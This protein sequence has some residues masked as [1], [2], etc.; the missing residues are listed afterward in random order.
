MED[1][2]DAFDDE[3]VITPKLS[4]PQL[5]S[6]FLREHHKKIA[7]FSSLIAIILL[8][9]VLIILGIWI[10]SGSGDEETNTSWSYGVVIDMGSSGSRIHVFQWSIN[11]PVQPAPHGGETSIIQYNQKHEHHT[12]PNISIRT[13][14]LV[15]R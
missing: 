6:I 15:H 1:E 7:L 10:F 11:D 5:L 9:I 13:G 8:A 12:E 3:V 14:L 2:I 4:V